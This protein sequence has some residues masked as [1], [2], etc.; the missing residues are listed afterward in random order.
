MSKFVKKCVV[1]GRE[2]TV[3]VCHTA[4][5]A[6][7]DECKRLR[8]NQCEMTRYRMNADRERAKRMERYARKRLSEMRV[9]PDSA[10]RIDWLM[11]VGNA[12][13][14][15]RESKRWSP[16]ERNYAKRAY[17]KMHGL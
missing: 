11:M 16:A 3:D 6:C 12:D 8:R 10:A 5:K 1:C 17:E 7:S 14:L 2:F 4:Q 13:L 9:T 15:R